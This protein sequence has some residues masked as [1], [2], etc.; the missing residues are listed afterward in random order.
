MKR[1]SLP[2]RK[3]TVTG[4]PLTDAQRNRMVKA[5]WEDGKQTAFG[6]AADLLPITRRKDR[7]DRA[8]RTAARR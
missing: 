8:R 3:K 4:A 2:S 7:H 5:L 1:K 6:F